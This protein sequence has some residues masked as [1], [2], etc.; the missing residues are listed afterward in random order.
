MDL[1]LYIQIKAQD[2]IRFGIPMADW[3]RKQFP[4]AQQ[5]DADN[6]SE[7]L[8]INQELTMLKEAKSCLLLIDTEPE[9]KP[10]KTVRLIE[11]IVRNKELKPVVHLKG[12][13]AP[14]EKMLKLGKVAYHQNL[15]EETLKELILNAEV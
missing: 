8:V 12:S 5:L 13:N 1:L 6:F 7:D 3:Y 10:G 11:S 14:I 15:S 2:N 9:A 4:E